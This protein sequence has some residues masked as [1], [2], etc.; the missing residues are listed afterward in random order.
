[1]LERF[2]YIGAVIVVLSITQVAAQATNE[3]IW[4]HDAKRNIVTQT[5]LWRCKFDVVS[6]ARAEAIK[7]QRV[8]R[9]QR[10]LN[11]EKNPVIPGQRMT[12]AGSGF[13]ISRTGDVL[14]N[15]HVVKG[16]ASVTIVPAGGTRPAT[17]R[18]ARKGY[19]EPRHDLAIIKTDFM[20]RE[21]ARFDGGNGP[22]LTAGESISVVGYPS[23]GRV[24]IKPK[25]TLGRVKSATPAAR[26]GFIT[27]AVDVRSGNSGGPVLDASGRAIGVVVAK[28]NTPGIYAK[29]GQLVREI[30]FAIPL[31][32]VRRFTQK[33]RIKLLTLGQREALS[34]EAR[35]ELARNFVVQVRCWGKK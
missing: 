25:M 17:E 29:T 35:F 30:G 31:G 2:F 11:R 19:G 21:P 14:T 27:M 3:R 24:A 6:S 5:E 22:L 34:D 15:F 18:I 8:Q 13:F 1:M 10:V 33:H 20:V 7:A 16:C 9:I 28:V 32:P 4:C 26:S 12:G 23:L